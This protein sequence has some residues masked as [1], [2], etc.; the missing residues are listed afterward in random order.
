MTLSIRQILA[1]SAALALFG[2]SAPAMAKM[3]TGS[4]VSDMTVTDTNG[5]THNLSDFAGKTVVLEWTNH[6]CPYV[7]KHY[8]TEFDGGNM[9]NLQKAA[10]DDD[11]V[12]L[13]VISSAPGKQGHVTAAKAN[14][15]SV[16]RGAV[17]AAVL[18]DEDGTAGR[19]FS[20]KTTP[21]MYV[22]NADQTLVY[23]G[24]IDDNRSSSPKTIEGA[25]NYV[26]EAL[27]AVKAGEAV[28]VGE[29]APYGCSVKYGS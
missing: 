12:W 25:R 6:K 5:V 26:T 15:L 2:T 24:A 3:A 29:T 1:A 28:A 16:E 7:K 11:V 4:T 20:A 19:A 9:Q 23:Q 18:L 13:S 22:I 21:H 10:A 8:N 17:P 27:A 14:Q